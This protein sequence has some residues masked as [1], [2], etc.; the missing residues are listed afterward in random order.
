MRLGKATVSQLEMLEEA[1]GEVQR[2]QAEL[3]AE[4]KT[5]ATVQLL[6]GLVERYALDLQATLGACGR[7]STSTDPG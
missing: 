3:K 2:L 4:P 5:K 1:K 6:P 7:D